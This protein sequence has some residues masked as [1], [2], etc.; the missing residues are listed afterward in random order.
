MLRNRTAYM[1]SNFDKDF[2]QFDKNPKNF[3]KKLSTMSSCEGDIQFSK[4]S[5]VRAQILA[6]FA[7]EIN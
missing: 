6:S 5:I 1:R 2:L 4:L 3:T 7:G